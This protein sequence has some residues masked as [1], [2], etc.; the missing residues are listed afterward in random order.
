MG[1]LKQ[2]ED[3]ILK[4]GFFVFFTRELFSKVCRIFCSPV[5]SV[6]VVCVQGILC[7]ALGVYWLD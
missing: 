4:Y 3:R 1:G 5:C 6:F 2:E 7:D